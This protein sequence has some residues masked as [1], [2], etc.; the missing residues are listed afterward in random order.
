MFSL[1]SSWILQFRHIQYFRYR[2][3]EYYNLNSIYLLPLSRILQL[4]HIQCFRYRLHEH[5][6]LNIFN[7][8]VIAFINI[9]LEY[10]Q[11]FR[12]YRL[13][14]YYNLDIFN[15]FIIAFMNIIIITYLM[16]SLSP[17]WI[18]QLEHIQ[19]FRY[20]LHQYYN[21]NIFNVFVIAF[22]NIT[23]W[24]YS[25]FSLSHSR[26]KKKCDYNAKNQDCRNEN[27]KS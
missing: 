21:F 10:I 19:C 24:T 26:T 4:R 7:V 13:Y 17:S 14:E 20:H 1:S 3:H 6:N 27:S 23:T 25:I 2:L 9:T 18:L 16:S 11:C 8:F 22:I 5:Y 12:Y 15:I